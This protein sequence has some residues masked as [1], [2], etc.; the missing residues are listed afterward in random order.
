MRTPFATED[1]PAYTSYLPW[2]SV[3]PEGNVVLLA[4]NAEAVPDELGLVWRLGLLP[5]EARPDGEIGAI[6]ARLDHLLGSLP[7][8]TPVQF[9]LRSSRDV[10][11]P[12]ENWQAATRSSDPVLAELA[13]SRRTSLERLSVSTATC[14]FEARSLEVLFTVVRPGSWTG[15]PVGAIEALRG[16]GEAAG[17]SAPSRRVSEAYAR[18]R[19]KILDLGRSLESL[20]AQTGLAFRRLPEADL[21]EELHAALNPRRSLAMGAPD[22]LAGELLRERVALSGISVDLDEGTIGLD[23]TVL[24]VVSVTHLPPTTHAGM[25]MRAAQ[26]ATFIDTV[27]EMDLVLNAHVLDQEEVRLRFGG[28]RRLAQD[29]SRDAHQGPVMGAHVAEL[30]AIERDLA[31]GGRVL[32]LRIHAIVR[33]RSAEEASQRAR[34][35][36]AAFQT[37]GFRAVVEDVLAPTLWLGSLPLSYRPDGDRFLRR[38]RKTLTTN[39]AHLLPVWGAFGGSPQAAQ[40][41]LNRRGEPVTLGFFNGKEVPHGL[42]TGKSGA[43]K[44]VYANDLILNALRTGGR[45]WVLDRGGSYR[46]LAE[47]LDGAYVGYDSPRPARLNPCGRSGPDGSCPEETNN[48]LRDWLTEMATQGKQD[49]PVRDRN[50]FSIAVRRA[51]GGKPGQEIFLRDVHAALGDLSREHP[52][53][54]DLTLS[55]SEYVLDGPYARFFDGPDET[56]FGKALV[57]V[58]LA[59]AALEDAVTSVLVMALMHRIAE[60][61][62]TWLSEDKYLVIDEAWTLLKSPACARFIENISRTARKSRLSLV[63]LSQQITDLE[64]P[65][66]RAILAQAST[67]ICLHQDPEAIRLAAGLLGLNPREVE[68]YQSLRTLPGVYSEFLVKGPFGSGVA[69]LAMDPFAYWLTTSDMADRKILDGLLE[70]ARARG[71]SGREA[72]KGAILE[73]ALKHPRGA[74]TAAAPAGPAPRRNG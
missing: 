33:G 32:T 43:G 61:A 1:A 14:A 18:D 31:A 28:S 51:F 74:P 17:E 4:A 11:R 16:A 20:M 8:R 26:G 21:A 39:V 65:S 38:S 69:R 64:G 59:D 29:Q 49:L 15:T 22:A 35:V 19:R 10:R 70:K 62:R 48:F 72:L 2:H 73:A 55:I 5:A 12:I 9:I 36:Q 63:I 13:R 68:L 40:I 53:A 60:G 57:A 46:K 52:A 54:K 44:S 66:G 71:A 30:A 24:K 56:D 25:L 23:E 47:V 34:S 37:A 58:D 7:D 50:L 6:A 42:V 67:K 27:P 41:L 45:V 3:D